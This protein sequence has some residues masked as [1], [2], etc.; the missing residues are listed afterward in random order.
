MA[1]LHLGILAFWLCSGFLL[2]CCQEMLIKSLYTVQ[3]RC[4]KFK[5]RAFA[6]MTNAVRFPLCMRSE[7][8]YA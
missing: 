3:F 2:L 5:K 8:K 4:L 6:L 7:A 1:L